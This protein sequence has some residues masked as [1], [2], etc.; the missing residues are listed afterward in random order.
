MVLRDFPGAFEAEYELWEEGGDLITVLPWYA[1]QFRGDK[2]YVTID[3]V[4]YKVEKITHILTSRPD[5][6][7]PVPPAAERG[8]GTPSCKIEVSLVP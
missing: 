8:F 4:E 7:G 5:W 6:P 1:C 3:D 2:Q